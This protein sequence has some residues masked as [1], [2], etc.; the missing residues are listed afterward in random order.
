MKAL[1]S[2]LAMLAGGVIAA[3]AGADVPPSDVVY[4]DGAI[5]QPLTATPGDPVRGREIV[6]TKSLGN[7]VSCHQNTDML[8]IP[9]HGE[10]GP[11]FDGVSERWSIA[12]LRGI[13]ANSK[14]MFPGTIMPAFY[15]VDGFTR[16]GD[17]YTGKPATEI[18]P[19]LTAQQIEDVV[20]YL[21]T[22]KYPE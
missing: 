6:G 15:K 17:A 19:I 8:D 20:A 11:T 9:W 10:I 22:L 14:M 1:T 18:T 5:A 21:A 16:P 12:E 4:Q 7:C 3:N 13:V 2:A